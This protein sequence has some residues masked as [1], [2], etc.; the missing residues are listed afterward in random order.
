MSKK[1][2]AAFLFF[3]LLYMVS[4]SYVVDFLWLIKI[5]PI[6]LLVGGVININPSSTRS[7]LLLALVFSGCGDL[8]LAFDAFILG[9][10]AFL[11]AQ[12]SYA[13]LFR[14]YW[15]GLFKRWPLNFL[16]IIYMFGMAWLLIPNLDDLQIPVMA[17]L[18][19][20]TSMGLL[21]FQSSLPIC[22]AVL[23]ALLFIISDSFIA[24][25]KFINPF[26]FESYW[27]MRTYYAAQ[28]MLVT[29]FVNSKKQNT[30]TARLL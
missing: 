14:S 7:I 26:P 19:T 5:I 1:M 15:Q 4:L 6:A 18:I 13:F 3:V 24:I 21:A 16:L 2:C 29:G 17:Y 23:G 8:F 12:L 20:I 27:I 30:T 28:F 11:L 22:W 25:N 9:V 10:A